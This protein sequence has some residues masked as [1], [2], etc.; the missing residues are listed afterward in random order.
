[1]KKKT[2]I[3]SLVA[4]IAILAS[5]SIISLFSK[6]NELKTQEIKATILSKNK[7]T[8]TVQDKDDII[9]TFKVNN[10]LNEIGENIFIE[11]T[12]LLNKNTELQEVSIINY[13]TITT[14]NEDDELP[15]DWQ[16]NGIF[17]NYYKLAYNKLKTLTI[18]EKIGQLF[19]VRYPD[20][21]QEEL[22]KKYKFSGYIFFEKDFTGKTKDEVK[23][24][25]SSLQKV[26]NIPLLTAVD[27]EGGK[28]VRVS[29]NS[30][31]SSEKFASPSELYNTGG[32]ELIK[33]DTVK[34]SSLLKSLG[35]NLN[36]APVV[37]VA[38]NPDAYI[39]ERTLKQGTDLTSQYS[40]T[41]I[42]AS[43]NTGVSYTLKHFP[44]YSNNEDTHTQ[45]SSDNRTY[46]E[47]LDNDLPPFSSG[48]KAGAEAVL[49]NHNTVTSLDADNPASLSPSVHNLL[50]NELDFTGIIIT[51]DLSMTAL[52]TIDNVAVKAILAGNN[53]LITTNYQEDISSVKKAITDGTLSESTIDK[54]AF[55]ILAWKYYKGLLFENQK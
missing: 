25:M 1:M 20:S 17:K 33:E 18:D 5:I 32:F 24:M 46:D 53:L 27:E 44:G 29:N 43:K 49:V 34:K 48:I 23:N 38:T 16:D 47:I 40:S 50:R 12:G 7:D 31:L 51:D 41:V 4:V 2:I 21:N 3:Y 35:L 39:Y 10:T 26:S 9:Y 14:L 37:D 13:E 54:L 36:L 19:L 52:S 30:N 11:Y 55:K 8:I 15:A 28:V 22:L 45:T 6:N 42:S